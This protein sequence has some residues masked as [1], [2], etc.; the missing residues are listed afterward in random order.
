MKFYQS[1]FKKYREQ[2]SSE[3]F[4][5]FYYDYH[6]GETWDA[7][8]QRLA[9]MVKQGENWNF[10][11]PEYQRPGMTIP[12]LTN[13]L[14]NT[15]SRLQE[16]GK[17]RFSIDNRYACFN[18]GLQTPDEKDIFATFSKN[19]NSANVSY[20]DW[21]FTGFYDSYQRELSE[22]RPLPDIATYIEHASDLVLDLSYEIDINIAH[23]LDDPENQDRLPPPLRHN[24]NLAMTAI[25][26]ATKFL[27]QKVLRNYKTAIPFWYVTERRIQLL[28]PLCLM[29]P[30]MADL[31][32]VA[33]KDDI[34]KV[35]RI[36]TA[37]RMD[38]AYINARLLT[39]P[40]REWLNP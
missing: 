36:R 23:I 14:N 12:I 30:D 20:C 18:T 32:L 10:V 7:P 17:V 27:K 29:Q 25:E 34:G 8:F 33:D 16:Q 1:L 19:P 31:A 4:S 38:M 6:K 9:K 15:F 11:R 21:E 22:F 3:V 39:R 26:G 24:R 2:P 40:D 37:L 35:Y 13:Y 28:L 5:F